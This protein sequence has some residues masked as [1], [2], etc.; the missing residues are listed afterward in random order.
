[1]PNKSFYAHRVIT[2]PDQT[3]GASLGTGICIVNP[4]SQEYGCRSYGSV[5]VGVSDTHCFRSSTG[6]CGCFIYPIGF[7]ARY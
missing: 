6:R 3:Q 2:G 5:D 4:A 7:A 1:M